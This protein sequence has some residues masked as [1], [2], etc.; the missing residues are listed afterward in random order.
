MLQ[1][2]REIMI[3]VKSILVIF[4]VA[5]S[6]KD[7]FP[8]DLKNWGNF[9]MFVRQMD[10]TINI[11]FQETGYKIPLRVVSESS[12][13]GIKEEF[14]EL[15]KNADLSKILGTDVFSSGKKIIVKEKRDEVLY[16]LYPSKE[17]MMQVKMRT[18]LI[19]NASKP[20]VIV[21]NDKNQTQQ[22]LA[23]KNCVEIA[24]LKDSKRKAF[25]M[26]GHILVI[27]NKSK[28]SFIYNSLEDLRVYN[29]F[30]SQLNEVKP[31]E[32]N[33]KFV[34]IDQGKKVP[35]SI[36][37][38][39]GQ[40]TTSTNHTSVLKGGK[41]AY[42]YYEGISLIFE[43][44]SDFDLFYSKRKGYVNHDKYVFQSVMDSPEDF[45]KNKTVLSEQ[46]VKDLE[47]SPE[48]L[49]YSISS[50][51]VVEDELN[52][53]FLDEFHLDKIYPSLLAYMGECI[54]KAKGGTWVFNSESNQNKTEKHLF[55][56]TSSDKVVDFLP[57]LWD[58]LYNQK[59]TGHC[60]IG[61]FLVPI[62]QMK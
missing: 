42:N 39:Q 60:S 25:K 35:I 13:E 30:E 27:E 3:R 1:M 59:E 56:R 19:L 50:L 43:S 10:T 5:L 16:L 52:K 37:K 44:K 46:L 34:F 31:I 53:Y 54:I 33:K 45:I 36:V 2:N 61:S 7:V 9:T 8:A 51:R 15:S 55:I 22:L 4:A 58:E 14:P 26:D 29:P 6:I 20:V 28:E 17:D 41:I 21:K 32:S 18:F 48:K 23:K 24:E 40:R 38:H 12:F 11:E 47:I 49:D 57:N 62:M